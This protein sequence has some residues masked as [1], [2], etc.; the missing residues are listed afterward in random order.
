MKIFIE[1]L[2]FVGSGRPYEVI[3][4]VTSRFLFKNRQSQPAEAMNSGFVDRLHALVW[5]DFP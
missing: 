5:I 1:S 2:T 4:R 3:R